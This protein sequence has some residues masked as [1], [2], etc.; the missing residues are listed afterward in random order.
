MKKLLRESKNVNP[1]I[2]VDPGWN[3]GLAVWTGSDNLPYCTDIIVE[4]TRLKILKLEED[5]IEWMLKKF[6]AFVKARSEYVKDVYI[7]GA[8][9][10]SSSVR[11]MAAAQKGDT[12]GL[13]YIIGG[14][15]QI[16][17]SYGLHPKVINPTKWKA[18]LSKDK[19]IERLKRLY[20]VEYKEHTREAVGLGL[21]VKGVL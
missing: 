5:R 18:Q 21:W 17:Y 14:Y 16:C 11:S 9:L 4:P 20:D 6:E 10:W 7:E 13:A 1:F 12:F 19:L 2:S 3:T 8:E 15:M